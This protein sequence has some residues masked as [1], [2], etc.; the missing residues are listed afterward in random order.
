MMKQTTD[1]R[2]PMRKIKVNRPDYPEVKRI[3]DQEK[4]VVADNL[5]AYSDAKIILLIPKGRT[6]NR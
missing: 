1:T 5:A 6:L 2:Y 3:I 4:K